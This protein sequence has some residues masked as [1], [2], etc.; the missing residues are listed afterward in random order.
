[1]GRQ[2]DRQAKRQTTTKVMLMMMIERDLEFKM[3]SNAPA[4]HSP[5]DQ[6]WA[7][8][9]LECRRSNYDEPENH[10]IECDYYNCAV[11]ESY[12]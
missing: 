4:A 10:L 5:V 1:M 2:T 8:G 6:I 12:V 3:K 7:I 11:C 9:T